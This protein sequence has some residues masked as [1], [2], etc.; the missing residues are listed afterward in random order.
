MSCKLP[1]VMNNDEY[2]NNNS[3][4][5]VPSGDQVKGWTTLAYKDVWIPPDASTQYDRTQRF[6]KHPIP[7][8]TTGLKLETAP[9]ALGGFCLQVT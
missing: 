9:P 7:D 2:D 6:S 3:D 5:N 4:G 8:L 1:A